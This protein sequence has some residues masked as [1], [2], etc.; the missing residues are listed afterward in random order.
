MRALRALPEPQRP[1]GFLLTCPQLP[2][3]LTIYLAPSQTCRAG[4]LQNRAAQDLP[5]GLAVV[6]DPQISF[7]PQLPSSFL[8][9]FHGLCACPSRF[10]FIADTLF[11]KP[12]RL[13]RH[14]LAPYRAEGPQGK[15]RSERS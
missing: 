12:Y 14:Y 8:L 15:G 9:L 3:L 5:A 4:N 1:R 6:Y 11:A 13:P 10:H 2:R 7:F